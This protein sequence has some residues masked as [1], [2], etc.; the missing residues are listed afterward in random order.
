MSLLTDKR[1]SDA[2]QMNTIYIDYG[3]H[4]YAQFHPQ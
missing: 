4:A 2:V 1:M 3:K